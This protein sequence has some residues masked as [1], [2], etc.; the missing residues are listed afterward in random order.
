[1]STVPDPLKYL[2]IATFEDGTK[3]IQ[4]P[5]DRASDYDPEAEHNASAFRDVVAMS[6]LSKLL[7][8]GLF[9][10]DDPDHNPFAAVRLDD[11]MFE[12]NGWTFQAHPQNLDLS[13][14]ELE[15][16]F[17]R[18]VR[19]DKVMSRDKTQQE[20]RHYVNRYIIGWQIKG[21]NFTQTVCIA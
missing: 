14:K 15:V 2:F 7:W 17:F 12:L 21:E 11:G 5:D 4:T 16:V 19:K 8:F 20:I 1:M 6:K 18:E 13:D 3:I 10:A 9:M